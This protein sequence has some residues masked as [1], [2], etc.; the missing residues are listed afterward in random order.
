MPI[1]RRF[2]IIQNFLYRARPAF[3]AKACRAKAATGFCAKGPTIV[4]PSKQRPG[5]RPCASN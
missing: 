3:Y 5:A 4:R 2:S 1:L